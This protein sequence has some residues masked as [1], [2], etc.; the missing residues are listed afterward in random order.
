MP[1]ACGKLGQSL[2]DSVQVVWL[3]AAQ[4]ASGTQAACVPKENMGCASTQ[5][6]TGK[7]PIQHRQGVRSGT[8]HH[9][10]GA[11]ARGHLGP[12]GF[13]GTPGDRG[14]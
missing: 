5:V 13:T 14:C 4:F 3:S 11:W 7:F 9:A 2:G 12:S 8:V 1:R 6:G 10:V